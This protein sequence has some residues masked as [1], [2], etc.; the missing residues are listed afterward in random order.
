M[1]AR[2]IV[3]ALLSGQIAVPHSAPPTVF[4]TSAWQN[5]V[6]VVTGNSVTGHVPVSDLKGVG[7]GPAQTAL[8]R[9]GA[10]LYVRDAGTA[11]DIVDTATGAVT[12]TIG[13]GGPIGVTPDGATLYV[14]ESGQIEAIGTATRTVTATIPLPVTDAVLSADGTRIEVLDGQVVTTVDTAT[15]TVTG[16]TNLG[17]GLWS[18]LASH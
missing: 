15:N 13:D 5:A 3:G 7:T 11:I 17:T 10:T 12:G 8:S 2:L 16:S 18:S 1:F 4:V 14:A 6:A 9:D